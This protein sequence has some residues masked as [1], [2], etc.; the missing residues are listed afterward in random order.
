[1]GFLLYEVFSSFASLGV[2]LYYSWKLTLVIISSFPIAATGLYFVSRRLG[3]AIE[4]QKRELTQASKYA[5]TAMSS[6]ITVKAYNGQD[7]EIWQYYE[8]I[9]KVA[10]CYLIQ[11]AANAMQY[12]ITKFVMVSIFVQGFWFG[13]YLVDKGID[14]GH[15]LTTFYACLNA[16]Q[17]M[18]TVLP[19]WM[20]LAKGISA[21]Q[22]LQSIR[23]QMQN[24]RKVT[25]MVGSLRPRVCFGDIELNQV[26]S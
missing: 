24:G 12:G 19:E 8:T 22:T 5:N 13:L 20:V 14:P 6:I 10:A 4:A 15:V 21:G 18:E 7:H 9:K 17:A 16:M 1:M 23:V 11:A 26:S 2:A 3:P 25:K